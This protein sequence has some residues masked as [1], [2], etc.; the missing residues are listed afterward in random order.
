MLSS[1]PPQTISNKTPGSSSS[2]SSSSSSCS[3][4]EELQLTEYQLRTGDSLASY[5]YDY[6]DSITSDPTA[7]D[8]DSSF[9]V[10]M[11]ST[12]RAQKIILQERSWLRVQ[13][14][15]QYNRV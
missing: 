11:I 10:K 1:L 12:A 13:L 8:S 3:S 2:S 6:S 15:A 5:L 14:A 9:L 4:L 7:Q